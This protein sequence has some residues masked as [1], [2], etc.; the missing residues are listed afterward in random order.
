[1]RDQAHAWC[2]GLGRYRAGMRIVAG[3]A[4]GRTLFA[5]PGESVR[6]TTERVREAIFNSLYSHGEVEGRRFLD[7]FAGSGALG[8]EALSRGAASCTFIDSDRVCVAAI[9]ENVDRLGFGDVAVVRQGEA[10]SILSSLERHDVAL[11]DPP[12]DFGTW[13]DLLRD[14]PA[15]VVVIEA[16]REVEPGP[17]WQ[18][19]K[20]KRYGGTVVTIARRT[21][22]ASGRTQQD[23]RS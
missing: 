19:L 22:E 21:D 5:P 16:S 18:I 14:V 6:P 10:I 17:G 20:A 3:T 12:Y 9:A 4:G 8:L 11:L 1:M 13:S 23:G 15:D 7:M 2:A